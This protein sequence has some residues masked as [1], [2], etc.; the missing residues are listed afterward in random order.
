MKITASLL[1]FAF[2]KT[3]SSLE[4]TWGR[5]PG[6]SAKDLSVGYAK[7]RAHAGI[8]SLYYR[9]PSLYCRTKG[10]CMYCS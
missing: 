6:S 5:R 9:Q 1:F 2:S 7:D 4:I 3:C 10:V 8:L